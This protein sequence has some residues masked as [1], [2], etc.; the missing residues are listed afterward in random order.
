MISEV[1]DRTLLLKLKRVVAEVIDQDNKVDLW[2]ELTAEQQKELEAALQESKQEENLVD[3]QVVI[4][5]Y[6]QWQKK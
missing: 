6:Q 5:K 4:D 3:H 1:K 2:D